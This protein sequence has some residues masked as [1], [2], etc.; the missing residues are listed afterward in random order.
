MYKYIH[1]V[2]VHYVQGPLLVKRC[3]SNR[4]EFFCMIAEISIFIYDSLTLITQVG[5]KFFKL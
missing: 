1:F 2:H 3:R 5:L 4:T